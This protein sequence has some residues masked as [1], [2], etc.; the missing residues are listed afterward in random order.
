MI[1]GLRLNAF[2][3]TL[4]MLILLRGVTVGLTNGNTLYNLPEAFLYP[5]R[6]AVADE[7]RRL[8]RRGAG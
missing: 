8:H 2:I 6:T 3:A 5:R 4:A 1:V 7:R